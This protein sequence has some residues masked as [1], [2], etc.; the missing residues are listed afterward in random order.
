[1]YNPKDILTEDGFEDYKA[2]LRNIENGLFFIENHA[3]DLHIGALNA[4]QSDDF[5]ILLGT[6]EALKDV[7]KKGD[8]EKDE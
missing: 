8:G 6:W 4:K 2:H 3:D 5:S 7:L 1:M